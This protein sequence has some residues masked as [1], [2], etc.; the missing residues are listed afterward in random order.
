MFENPEVGEGFI[1]SG[2]VGWH[3]LQVGCFLYP[4]MMFYSEIETGETLTDSKRPDLKCR[5]SKID[6]NLAG[7]LGMGGGG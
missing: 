5:E 7:N 6:K 3:G 1:A 2:K 4:A